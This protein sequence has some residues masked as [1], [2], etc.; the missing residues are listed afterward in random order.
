MTPQKANNHTIEYLVESEEDESSV[1]DIKRMMIRMFKELRGYTK[2]TH[3]S[4]ETNI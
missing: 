1:A 2:T 4:Q 3:E